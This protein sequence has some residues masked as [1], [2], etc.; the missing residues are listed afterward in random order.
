MLSAIGIFVT[1]LLSA[2]QVYAAC[3]TQEILQ[4]KDQGLS[5]AEIEK[6]CEASSLPEWLNGF[7]RVTKGS[8]ST[9]V[10]SPGGFGSTQEIVKIVVQNDT[11]TI[12]ETRDYHLGTSMQQFSRMAV[13]DIRFTGKQLVFTTHVRNS[14]QDTRTTYLLTIK[15]G[16]TGRLEGR[17]EQV[18]TGFPPLPPVRFAGTVTMQK[19]PER[20]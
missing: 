18:D 10:P 16:D 13:S 8:E 9:N 6:R 4:M 11:L 14:V 3:T 5:N 12:F 7:W 1:I 19:L 2:A 20:G 17:Y 15:S